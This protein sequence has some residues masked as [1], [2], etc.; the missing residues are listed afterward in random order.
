M[1]KKAH[2]PLTPK[3]QRFIQEYLVDLCGAK[4]AIRAGYSE[5]TARVRSQK[6]LQDPRITDA[7]AKAQER[8]EMR[9]EVTQDRVIHELAASAF[10][11]ARS[12]F[13]A[14]GTLKSPDQWDDETAAAMA[15]IESE[16]IFEGRGKSRKRVGT[17]QRVKRWDKIKALELLGRHLGMWNDKLQVDVMPHE[18]RLAHL[19]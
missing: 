3:M 17:L 15:G 9:T 13:N 7:I 6:L 10:S 12:L 1:G 16:E 11:D 5:R 4:A 19:K 14:D 18:D 8:R 2:L